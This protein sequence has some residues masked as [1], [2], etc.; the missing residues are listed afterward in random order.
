MSSLTIAYFGLKVVEEAI[1]D[2]FTRNGLNENV[3]EEL[4]LIAETNEDDFFQ[5]VDNFVMRN[6]CEYD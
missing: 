1:S 5:M 6:E 3:C 4:K 2:Y